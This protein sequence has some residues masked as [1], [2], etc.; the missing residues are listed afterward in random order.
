MRNNLFD[1]SEDLKKK[2][3]INYDHNRENFKKKKEI[4]KRAIEEGKTF[5]I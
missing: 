5:K 1:K 3:F 4:K 2:S